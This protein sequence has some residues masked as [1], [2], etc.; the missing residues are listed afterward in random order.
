[1]VELEEFHQNFLQTILSD[2]ESRGLMTPQAFFETVCEELISSGDLTVNYTVAE[3]LKNNMEVYGYDYDEER[4]IL[5]ILAHQFYQDNELQTLTKKSIETKL[6]R[7]KAFFIKCTESIHLEMEETD[8]AYSMAYFIQQYLEQNSID[9]VR[10]MVITDGKA[11]RNLGVLPVEEYG[12]VTLESRVIDINYIYKLYLLESS[13]GGFE[14]DVNYPCLQTAYNDSYQSYLAVVPGQDLVNIYEK[15]GQKL[16]EQNVRTFLQ[17]RGNVNR[18]LRATIKDRPE[19]FF[20]YNNGITATATNVVLDELG[21][22]IKIENLQIVNGG[23]TTS[24]IYAASKN[25]KLDVSSVSVQM[26]LSVVKEKIDTNNFIS[27]VAEYANTQ[28]KVNPSD[29]FSNSPFHKDFNSYAKRLRVPATDGSQHQTHWFYERVRGE[30][31][32]EQAYLTSAKKKQFLID[33]PKSQLLDKTFLSKSENAWLQKPDVVCKGAQFSSKNFASEITDQL[34]KDGLAI[35][36]N[37]FKDTVSRVILFRA[38]EKMVSKA[39]W[40]DGGFRAQTVAYAMSHL[41]YIVQQTG[42][43]L[44]FSLIWEKQALPLT[45]RQFLKVTTPVIYDCIVNPIEGFANPTQWS[46]KEACWSRVKGIS[47][48]ASLDEDLL[49][50]S[51]QEKYKKKEDKSQKR[52]D[53]GIEIQSYVVSVNKNIWIELLS[54]YDDA[55]EVSPVQRDIIQKVHSGRIALPSE[56]QSKVIYELL[57]KAEG[58][59]FDSQYLL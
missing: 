34:E 36:E 22:L 39:E 8:A 57:H 16:F 50:D 24:A 46:K 44:N 25:G 32:N 29:F 1:M 37:Y 42:K 3:Y 56:R 9:T 21:N 54:Y 41:A 5:T 10:L 33:N 59:G 53:N 4:H 11:T 43:S 28:N 47:F 40:Y 14:V 38:I 13:G 58:E 19:M 35:T 48:N 12:N 6:K 17:F 2:A 49:I 30:Y 52:L 55:D 51:E 27:K 15:H 26:K 23:Q 18:G 7:L 31:L 45:L 20:A